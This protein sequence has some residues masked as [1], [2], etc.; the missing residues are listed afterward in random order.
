MTPQ[1]PKTKYIFVARNPKDCV[2]SFFHH[3][4]GFIKHYN[5]SDGCFDTFFDLFLHGKVD[6]GDYFTTLRSWFDHRNDPN[7]LFL[8]YEDLRTGYSGPEM[9]SVADFLDPDIYPAR[10]RVGDSSDQILLHSSLESMKKDPTRFSSERPK[11][12]TPFIRKGSVGGWDELLSEE[13]SCLLDQRMRSA[14]SDDER[15]VLGELYM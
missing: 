13:Q 5:F 6:F 7:V 2:V 12:H 10:L 9:L 3:T 11:E 1:N 15:K 4:R 8:T 14:F